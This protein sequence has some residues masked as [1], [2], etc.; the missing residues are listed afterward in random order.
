[1]QVLEVKFERKCLSIVKVFM[2]QITILSCLKIYF[3]KST[4]STC[5]GS[6][7]FLS[8]S[9]NFA[10]VLHLKTSVSWI[11][12]VLALFSCSSFVLIIKSVWLFSLTLVFPI[13]VTWFFQSLSLG[14]SNHC[15]L[16]LTIIVTW[17]FQSL[18]LGFSNR[19]NTAP[20]RILKSTSLISPNHFHF[21]PAIIVT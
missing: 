6:G 19:S 15:H 5:C 9:F 18:S 3:F 2:S 21:Y 7:S 11:S 4:T 8:F 12:F 1:M 17:F 16:V 13:I 14:F 10:F 20:N